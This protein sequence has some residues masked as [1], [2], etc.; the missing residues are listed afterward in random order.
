MVRPSTIYALSTP[1]GRS[2]VALVRMS[3]PD[4]FNVASALGVGTLQPRVMKR[5]TL[6]APQNHEVLDDAL[7]V[8][9]PQPHSFTGEDVV[10][11]NLH[12]SKAVIHAVLMALQATGLCRAAD[13]GEFSR[14]AFR[15][16]KMSLFELEGL[17][18]LIDSE[19][20]WQRKLAFSHYQGEAQQRLY[21]WRDRL[22]QA[23]AL[24]EAML[25]FPDE[26]DVP[27]DLLS[28]AKTLVQELL[29]ELEAGLSHRSAA[30]RLRDGYV[31]ALL[32]APNAGK[33]TLLNALAARDV[34][35]VSEHAGTTR[36]V[37][38][39]PVDLK[40]LPVTFVDTAGLRDT[41]H[42]IEREGIRRALHQAEQ[43]DLICVC[44]SYDAPL[45]QAERERLPAHVPIWWISTK[46]DVSSLPS[47]SKANFVVSAHKG[48]G[49]QTFLD[50]VTDIF[51]SHAKSALSS[52]FVEVRHHEA[53]SRCL[54]YLRAFLDPID[55][56]P[57]E[58]LAENLRMASDELA[59]VIG[60]MAPDDI[61]GAVFSRFCI[62]K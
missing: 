2:A 41:E 44:E 49:L 14:R 27:P 20:E 5:V 32:G 54:V 6:K 48:E 8:F 39:V 56:L 61:L 16:G 62:G 37:L 28:P 22:L 31:V 42:A 19:T 13:A 23:R 60:L 59:S 15:A 29:H 52:T 12:G 57:L 47:S 9:F 4:A 25:D 30:E 35:I 21:A 34:A 3:G 58:L 1:R 11:F 17:A 55:D 46:A 18:E 7:V 50:S 24:L 38:C 10:E 36:D 43:A 26:G 45:G 51:S 40:G 33:S 53:V